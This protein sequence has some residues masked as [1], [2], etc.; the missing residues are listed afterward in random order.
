MTLPPPP[1][2]SVPPAGGSQPPHGGQQPPQQHG[3]QPPFGGPGGYSGANPN[4]PPAW[5][6]APLQPVPPRKRGNGWKWALGGVALVAVVGVTATVTLSVAN[7]GSGDGSSS[8]TGAPP[9]TSVSGAAHSDIASANDT[10]PVAVITEDPSCATQSPVLIAYANR[11]K[12]GW[13]KRDPAVPAT[14]W[15]PEMRGQYEAAGQA[16]RDTADQLVSSAKLTPHRVMRELYEQF[17]A[18]ARAYADSIP[19]YSPIDNELAQVAIRAADAID[20]ICAA[21]G[22]GSAAARGPLVEALPAPAGVAPVRDPDEARKF[23]T[24]PNPV[25]AEWISAVEDFGTNSDSWAKTSPDTPGVEW[26]PEQRRVTEEVIPAMNLLN[27][28]LSALGRKSGNP[29]VRDFADL[30]VQYRKA[31]LEALPTYTPADKY[32]ASASIRA[33]GLVASAC[34]ALG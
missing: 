12:N 16:F 3:G 24:E 34:R 11:T 4:Q 22:Y 1:S 14:E 10:G 20:R 28:Q 17:I 27:T 2:G 19:N 6:Q 25:C 8:A 9:T 15:A 7:K 31:Y 30:A 21:V 5:Q 18:Y 32:L 23:L 13:E 29:T 33:A 26:S